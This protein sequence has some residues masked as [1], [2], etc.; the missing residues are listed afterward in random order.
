M[1]IA[2]AGLMGNLRTSLLNGSKLGDYDRA[3]LLARRQMDALLA[4]RPL[5]K[6]GPI[7]GV[8]P[9][10]WTG[11]RQ[12]GWVALVT[13]FESSAPLGS[14]PAAGSRILERIAL[15]VWWMQGAQRRTMQLSAYRSAIATPE[16]VQAYQMGAGATPGAGARR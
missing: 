11:G 9:A 12:A 6:M 7:Q 15:E 3:A 14:P 16:D 2:V 10:E 4:T 8:F 13:P 1:G 5:P